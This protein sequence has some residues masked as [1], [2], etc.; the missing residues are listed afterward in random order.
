M[1]LPS[2]P[3]ELKDDELVWNNPSSGSLPLK[4]AY[5]HHLLLVNICIGPSLEY[6]YSSFHIFIG[7][8]TDA[9]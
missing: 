1:G 4:E 5:A 6:L 3:I 8:K 7:L 9:P 2:V